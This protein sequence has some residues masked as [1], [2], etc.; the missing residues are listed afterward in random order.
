M[1]LTCA[2]SVRVEDSYVAR[3]CASHKT[4]WANEKYV[5][6]LMPAAAVPARL[7][8]MPPPDLQGT[9]KPFAA[10][11][12]AAGVGGRPRIHALLTRSTSGLRALLGGGMALGFAAPLLPSE[13]D[14]RAA[15]LDQV[16]A[17]GHWHA[18]WQQRQH[19]THNTFLYHSSIHV[20]AA[21]GRSL[22]PSSPPPR[23]V[24]SSCASA[25][26][27]AHGRLAVAVG[28]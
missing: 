23:L 8:A 25:G 4:S 15:A 2:V 27:G 16:R 5:H 24:S 21:L 18:P 28:V 11:F 26:C 9:K 19:Q 14:R 20:Y 1:M 3:F 13:A 6:V 10:F 12:G 7:L 22:T 17:V